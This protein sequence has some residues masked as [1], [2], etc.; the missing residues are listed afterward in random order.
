M[1]D[2]KF[3]SQVFQGSRPKT[4]LLS[5][6]YHGLARNFTRHHHGQFVFRLMLKND[7]HSPKTKVFTK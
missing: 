6:Y 2:P 4:Y 5:I 3:P 1:L 7:L